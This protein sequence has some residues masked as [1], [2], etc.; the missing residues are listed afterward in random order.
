MSV[1]L[2][3]LAWP[4]AWPL[5]TWALTWAALLALQHRLDLAN[6]ALLYL[7]GAVLASLWP[8]VGLACLAGGVSVLVFNL[9]FVPPRGRL[10]VDLQ[11]HALLLGGLLA[12]GWLAAALMARLR[13]E[14]AAA[15]RHAE[16]AEQL[17][18]LA[19]RLRAAADPADEAPALQA[20][21][22]GDAV[23]LMLLRA[24]L[25]PRDEPDAVR[26]QGPADAERVAGLWL[27]LRG[28][29]A[30]GPGTP[31]HSHLG[32]W[33]LPLRGG[34]AAWGAAWVPV[35]NTPS[36]DP[37]A[38][39]QAQAL[40]DQMGQALQ[41]QRA[42]AVA[43]EAQA[44]AGEQALRNT[45]LAT[46]AH[47]LR[48]PLAALRSATSSLLAQDG[49]LSPA[50]RL[51]LVHTLDDEADQLH[52]MAENTLQ[53]ARLATP[54]VV[55]ARDWESLEEIVGAVV[56]RVRRRDPAAPLQLRVEAGLPPL[57]LDAV[58]VAQLLQNLLDNAFTHGAGGPVEL[59]VRR[60]GAQQLMAVRDRGPGVPPD[61][62]ARLFEVFE[63]GPAAAGTRGSGLGL[64]VCRAIA[65][66]HGATL[67]LRPRAHGGS[68]FEV[69][70]PTPE[71]PAVLP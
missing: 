16:Q 53:L 19:D 55:L 41:R 64:A 34:G 65:Q 20:A 70:W 24:E 63:R 33:C 14:A 31:R 1:T 66:A 4:V 50:Q 10:A 48:T 42:L 69:R 23:T 46:I 45:L 11:Q 12:I 27:C 9:L 67:T 30:F 71:S 22:G 38:Q 52:R 58:A 54:G 61:Q 5:A 39:A 43:A 21:L 59:L 26:L 28:G 60:E 35:E 37:A 6:L 13:R 51:R 40:C 44:R 25:P 15:R 47:D 2:Q 32:A 7:V 56:A 49:R 18:L 62:R 57:R 17:R 29:Q 3:R 36:A 68:A 8:P